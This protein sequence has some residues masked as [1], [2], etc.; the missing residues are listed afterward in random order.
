MIFYSLSTDCTPIYSWFYLQSTESLLPFYWSFYSH[1]LMIFLQLYWAFYYQSTGDSTLI[2]SYDCTPILLPF[3]SHSTG[4]I[5]P[6]YWWF[7]FFFL[8]VILLNSE[9]QQKLIA[10]ILLTFYWWFSFLWLVNPCCWWFY[11][12]STRFLLMILGAR[13]GVESPVESK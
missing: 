13:M 12:H 11:S 6:F 5:F 4:S 10:V 7:Y 9:I 8:L 2:L 1:L 3:Y